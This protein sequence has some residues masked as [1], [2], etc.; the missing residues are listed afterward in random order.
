MNTQSEIVEVL[1]QT[2]VVPSKKRMI[3]A[4]GTYHSSAES[5]VKP[6]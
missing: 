5:F 3:D 2:P 4:Y 1:K 6:F